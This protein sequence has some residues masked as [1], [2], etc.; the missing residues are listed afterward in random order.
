MAEVDGEFYQLN[1]FDK[2]SKEYYSTQAETL[3]DA[4]NKSVS[5]FGVSTLNTIELANL[6]VICDRLGINKAK[7]EAYE[8][9]GI[10]GDKNFETLKSIT[11]FCPVLQRYLSIKTIPPLKTIA[12]FDKLE[13]DFRRFVKN[14]VADKE[15]SVQEFR[16][17]VNLLFDMQ[18]AASPEDMGPDLMK[19]L[20]EKKDMTRISF[21][22]QI[23]NLTKGLSVN[24][25]SENNFETTELTFSFKASDIDEFCK[26][27]RQP[28][29]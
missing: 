11:Y 27:S 18:A 19:R 28:K 21:M 3:A 10:K 4:L 1:S 15:I 5:I 23:Q 2:Y 14:T 7:I 17:M 29:E 6:T 25:V 24:A 22:K 16:K 12:V 20:A 13:T 26:K 9:H 8:H